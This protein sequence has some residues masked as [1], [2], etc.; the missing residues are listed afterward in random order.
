MF[1]IYMPQCD[2]SV[3]NLTA[4]AKAINDGWTNG[5]AAYKT[6]VGFDSGFASS[7]LAF[8]FRPDVDPQTGNFRP[9][10]EPLVLDVRH[11]LRNF[12]FVLDVVKV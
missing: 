3:E 8:E 2:S 11:L 1:K 12:R 6:F 10:L 7:Y 5:K 4:I 9:V